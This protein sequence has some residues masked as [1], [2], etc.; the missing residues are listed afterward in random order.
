MR[1]VTIGRGLRDRAGAGQIECGVPRRAAGRVHLL[2]LGRAALDRDD[3]AALGAAAC[4]GRRE[5]LPLP[6]LADLVSR[7]ADAV[8]ADIDALKKAG[9]I[10]SGSN[11]RISFPFDSVHVDFTMGRAA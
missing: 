10:E 5:P 2:R 8:R 7:D 4:A 3:A 6:T 11:D 1:T 9:V